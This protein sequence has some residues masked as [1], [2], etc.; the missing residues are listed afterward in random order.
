M[1]FY[2]LL[3]ACLHGGASSSEIGK[4]N[5]I[6][7]INRHT[8][9]ILRFHWPSQ[10]KFLCHFSTRKIS[11]YQSFEKHCLL[12]KKYI[13]QNTSIFSTDT[14]TWEAYETREHPSFSFLPV[15]V[16]FFLL[17]FPPTALNI[18]PSSQPCFLLHSN[19]YKWV[20]D[21]CDII[22]TWQNINVYY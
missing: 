3:F 13:P 1:Q 17:Q 2:H 10:L 22:F 9:K 11:N 14:C 21:D 20:N 4:A 12:K 6:R 15:V 18:S 7:E 19:S 16:R 5:D 8:L